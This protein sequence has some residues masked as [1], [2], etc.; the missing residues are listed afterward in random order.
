MYYGTY[1]S[2]LLVPCLKD[3]FQFP[4]IVRTP[5]HNVHVIGYAHDYGHTTPSWASRFKEVWL[6]YVRG[7]VRQFAAFSPEHRNVI[8]SWSDRWVVWYSR[9]KVFILMACI[10]IMMEEI[11]HGWRYVL[12]W[13][14]NH[15]PR[16]FRLY[17][18]W[19]DSCGVHKCHTGT[20]NQ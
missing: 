1:R 17:Q 4:H 6:P 20:L 15:K 3:S 18:H 7:Y 11:I 19:V 13:E 5:Q 9:W 12:K 2:I 14:V 10:I 16:H 8:L